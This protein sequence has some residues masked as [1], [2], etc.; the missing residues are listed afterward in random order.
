MATNLLGKFQTREFTSWKGL[1]RDNHLGAI[2]SSAPQ[3]ASNLMIQML[4]AR[5]GRTLDT[6]L[7]QFPTKSFP[8]GDEYEWHL[9]GSDRQ[10]IALIEARDED[11]NVVVAGGNNVGAGTQPFYLVFG[12]DWFADGE[13]IVGNL[14]EIYQFRILGDARMEGTNAVNLYAA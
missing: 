13:Y 2:F 10:N 8:T 3:Q 1:T 11:G 9:T 4:A 12:K 14:N 7:S 6:L 5:R